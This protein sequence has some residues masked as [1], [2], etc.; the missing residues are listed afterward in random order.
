M[1]R[2]YESVSE[3]KELGAFRETN[4]R[5]IDSML[6]NMPLNTKIALG[7]YKLLTGNLEDLEFDMG[8]GQ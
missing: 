4:N 6:R 5:M 3:G 2:I 1:E 8:V 7:Y